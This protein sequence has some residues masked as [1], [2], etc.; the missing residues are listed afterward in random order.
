MVFI[1]SALFDKAVYR[2]ADCRP[3]LWV[4]GYVSALLLD[5]NE[6]AGSLILDID[7]RHQFTEHSIAFR[8]D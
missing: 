1:L 2:A 8:R 4:D 7:F 3:F 5:F 6:F